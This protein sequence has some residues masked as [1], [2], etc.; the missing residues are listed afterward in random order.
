VYILTGCAGDR[1]RSRRWI[2]FFPWPAGD[3]SLVSP[4]CRS[5]EWVLLRCSA[6]SHT[7]VTLIKHQ[8]LAKTY[9]ASKCLP[10]ASVNLM[11]YVRYQ[12]QTVKYVEWR[13]NFVPKLCTSLQWIVNQTT[14]YVPIK[15]YTGKE[16]ALTD[17]NSTSSQINVNMTS[18]LKF[19]LAL[20]I[21]QSVNQSINS[22]YISCSLIFTC[23]ISTFYT[24]TFLSKADIGTKNAKPTTSQEKIN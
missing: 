17:K 7:S 1:L 24:W 10:L 22:Y 15:L 3:L 11:Q 13:N 23:I 8:T 5:A 2:V 19:W 18:F 16:N 9:A 6:I 14:H 4:A 21:N 12:F 20:Y